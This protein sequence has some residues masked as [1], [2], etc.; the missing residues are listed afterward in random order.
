TD[1]AVKDLPRVMRLPGTLQLKDPSAPQKVTLRKSS[2]PRRWKL[3]ELTA[4]LGLPIAP[5]AGSR[6]TGSNGTNPAKVTSKVTPPAATVA[7]MPAVFTR[8]DA[9]RLSRLFGL[10]TDDLGAGI[11]TNIEEIRSAVSAI[12]PTAI[13]TE[14]KWMNFMRGLA[15][16]A[17]I[18]KSQAE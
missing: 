5:T 1:P 16:E 15:H 14:P 3:D 12:P 8:A 17:R 2:Q 6:P 18:F 7:A 9:E 11:E 13:S 10:V 4:T